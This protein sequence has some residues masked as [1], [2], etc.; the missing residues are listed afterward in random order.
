MYWKHTNTGEVIDQA[1]YDRLDYGSKIYFH[2]TSDRPTHK[3]NEEADIIE[4]LIVGEI[5][6][7][8]FNNDDD[9]D[10]SSSSFDTDS[11]SGG[12]DDGFG[13]GDFSGGGASG[14]F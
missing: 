6:S 7:S 3:Y 5:L 14:D 12:F 13:G 8:I 11:S 2:P 1:C 9:D 10:Y 4:T